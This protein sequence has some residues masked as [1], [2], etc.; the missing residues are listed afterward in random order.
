MNPIDGGSLLRL[1]DDLMKLARSEDLRIKIVDLKGLRDFTAT[2]TAD[3]D[4][5]CPIYGDNR[6]DSEFSRRTRFPLSAN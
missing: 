5:R 6:D 3:S 2:A 4:V 1:A